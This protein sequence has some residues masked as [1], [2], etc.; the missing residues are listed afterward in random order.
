MIT[1]AIALGQIVRCRVLRNPPTEPAALTETTT[2]LMKVSA[3][4][5]HARAIVDRVMQSLKFFPLPSE[6]YEIAEA[7]EVPKV[8]EFIAARSCEECRGTGYAP[9]LWLV[10]WEHGKRKRELIEKPIADLL[11]GKLAGPG[12]QNIYEASD[13]CGCE[14][15]EHLRRARAAK[16]AEEEEKAARR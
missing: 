7:T 10:T 15:G 13:Y 2:M 16:E 4:P 6:I 5:E 12:A 3:S 9:A 8:R 11:R 14:Y 1:E